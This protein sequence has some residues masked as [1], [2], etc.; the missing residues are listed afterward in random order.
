MCKKL[1]NFLLDVEFLVFTNI[2]AI[3]T[4]VRLQLDDNWFL[5]CNYSIFYNTCRITSLLRIDIFVHWKVFTDR[6]FQ[7]T[8][9]RLR[10][11][12]RGRRY[13]SKRIST[14]L[15]IGKLKKKL[16]FSWNFVSNFKTFPTFYC[17]LKLPKKIHLYTYIFSKCNDIF[18]FS[19]SIKLNGVKTF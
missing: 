15:Y 3:S 6:S 4:L 14:H 9:I 17:S 12:W 5:M 10:S 7:P 11:L 16:F 13:E 1:P 2:H 18:K 19:I 8:S